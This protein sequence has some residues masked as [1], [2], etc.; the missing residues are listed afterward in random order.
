MNCLYQI[1][2]E[3]IDGPNKGNCTEHFLR[4]PIHPC[5][6][7]FVLEALSDRVAE[8]VLSVALKF[9]ILEKNIS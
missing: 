1:K 7:L 5:N 6:Q 3:C 8:L 9:R 2:V 4:I